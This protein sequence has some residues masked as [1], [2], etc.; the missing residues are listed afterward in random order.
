MRPS[1][2]SRGYHL[3]RSLIDDV[4]GE[5]ARALVGALF[6]A[7]A[8]DDH[9]LD[10]AAGALRSRAIECWDAASETD[11][12][13]YPDCPP[14]ISESIRAEMLR[15]IGRFAESVEQAAAALA[16]PGVDHIVESAAGFIADRAARGDREPHTVDEAFEEQAEECD[17]RLISQAQAIDYRRALIAGAVRGL[18][19]RMRRPGQLED[20]VVFNGGGYYVQILVRPETLQVYAEAVDLDAHGMGSLGESERDLLERLGWTRGGEDD[21]TPNYHR[22]F[23]DETGAALAAEVA[24]ELELTLRLVYGAGDTTPL[25]LRVITYDT[26]SREEIS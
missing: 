17:P 4:L 25:G 15:R 1:R 3:C 18:L 11:D 26:E 12:P 6:A 19:P 14:G 8:C 13:A 10:A 9:G 5:P 21:G 2:S 7:W 22:T 20:A 16:L 23:A 24:R